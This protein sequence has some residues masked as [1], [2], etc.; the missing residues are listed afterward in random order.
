MLKWRVNSYIESDTND[1]NVEHYGTQ[2]TRLQNSP[3]GC[4]PQ[5]KQRT[6]KLSDIA[7]WREI[8]NCRSLTAFKTEGA[9]WICLALRYA[10]G[11]RNNVLRMSPCIYIKMQ[12][13]H[14]RRKQKNTDDNNIRT[15]VKTPFDRASNKWNL[16]PVYL[17]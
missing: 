6:E 3:T 15:I 12:W 4:S 2:G 10:F 17:I 1:F 7:D 16:S 14:R 5:K 8:A 13:I 11:V 9:I